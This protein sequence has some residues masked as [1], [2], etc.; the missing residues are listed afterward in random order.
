[1]VGATWFLIGIIPVYHVYAGSLPNYPAVETL[2]SL[3]SLL[4]TAAQLGVF[5]FAIYLVGTV[6]TSI[7]AGLQR[8]GLRHA[9]LKK[10]RSSK[11]EWVSQKGHELSTPTSDAMVLISGAASSFMEGMSP[12][13]TATIID[14]IVDEY[15]RVEFDLQDSR[16]LQYDYLDRLESEFAF[17]NSLWFPIGLLATELGILL[18][19]LEGWLVAVSGCAL[20]VVIKAQALDRRQEAETF[21]AEGIYSGRAFPPLFGDLVKRYAESELRELDVSEYKRAGWFINFLANR[22]RLD[23]A[24]AAFKSCW[25]LGRAQDPTIGIALEEFSPRT[26]ILLDA[27]IGSIYPA[28]RARANDIA[29]QQW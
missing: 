6:T 7:S 20:A 2:R 1:V 29:E 25:P 3:L 12:R 9:L 18:P 5:I 26:V 14:V 24:N 11:V 28:L 17:R 23:H 27:K 8:S 22:G 19:P 13:L 21:L 4:P 10:L 16:P 15:D